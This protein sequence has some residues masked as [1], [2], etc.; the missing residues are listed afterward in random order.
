MMA[1][2][3]RARQT[4]ILP[5]MLAGV[6]GWLF[7]PG[8]P[9]SR[10]SAKARAVRGAS[11]QDYP[12]GLDPERQAAM[13][14]LYSQVRAGAPASEEEA[15]I[16]R[17]F[18][19]GLPITQLEADVVIARA[20]FAYYVSGSELTKQQEVLLARYKSFVAQR[21]TDIRDLKTQLLNKR[22]AAAANAP[23]IATP[24]VAPPNDQCA[25][26]EVIPGA[27]PFPFTT[28]ITADITDAT[29]AGD[30][31]APS[32]QTNISRS[33][34]YRFTPTATAQYT[35]SSC[36]NA[37]TATTVDDTV[38]AIYTSSGGC[39]GTFTEVPSGV[40]TDG[41]DDDTCAVQAL[42]SVIT[43][44]LNAGTTYYI[45]MWLFDVVPPAAGQ[46]SVQLRVSQF[47]PASNDTCSG[48]IA[49]SLNTPVDA[50]TT[51][52][53][54]P[55]ANNDYNLSGAG[56]FS[57]IGQSASTADGID[58]VYSFTAPSAGNYSFRVF[59][60]ASPFSNLVLYVASSCPA[61]TPGTPV[62]VSTCLGASNRAPDSPAEEVMCLPL[63]LRQPPHILQ[64][65]IDA[66]PRN[67]RAALIAVW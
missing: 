5:L 10:A 57:G 63:A 51:S 9:L 29:T 27:G 35:I 24:Q 47:L 54:A 32:C 45:V 37:P 23:P 59:N 1:S 2:K 22:K 48:A 19:G 61:A 44:Q 8:L 58:V 60:Y 4:L 34:W 21:E 15:D 65:L 7:L 49:L 16:L 17:R 28:G 52:G 36:A 40:F 38:M 26:A 6:I 56:C 43:T 62:T 20:L 13:A 42:Q 53:T 66:L 12:S 33:I 11:M 55:I 67:W 41:C 25:G 14:S 64:N 31:P 46:T 18:G 50:T 30:P 3:K 39:A